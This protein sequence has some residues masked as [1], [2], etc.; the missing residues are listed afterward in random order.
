MIQTIRPIDG[1]ATN[2]I[3]MYFSIILC[4]ASEATPSQFEGCVRGPRHRSKWTEIYRPVTW[5]RQGR[6]P[7]FS[8][9]APT[10]VLDLVCFWTKMRVRCAYTMLIKYITQDIESTQWSM[11][12]LQ[13]TSDLRKWRDKL[14]Q[15]YR[16]QVW[17]FDRV[18][19]RYLRFHNE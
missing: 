13:V 14:V 12:C 1:T 19:L 5:W 10:L 15:V 18:S 3:L 9:Q 2:W 16:E 17:S 8:E 11:S 6:S 4:A 7:G